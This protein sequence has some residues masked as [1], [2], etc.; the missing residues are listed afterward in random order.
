MCFYSDFVLSCVQ[1]VALRLTDPPSKEFVP[2][3]YFEENWGDQVSSVR[4]SV[5]RGLERRS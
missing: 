1:V 3:S 2:R 4:E 5:K